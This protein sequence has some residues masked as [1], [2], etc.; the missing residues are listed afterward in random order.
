MHLEAMFME[1]TTEDEEFLKFEGDEEEDEEGGL[2][3]GDEEDTW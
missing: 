2:H 3:E 1:V